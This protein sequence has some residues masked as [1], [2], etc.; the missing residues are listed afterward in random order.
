[1]GSTPTPA[2]G[3]V[4]PQQTGLGTMVAAI[5][6][7]FSQGTIQKSSNPNDLAIQGN[8]FFVVQG[9]GNGQEFTRDGDFSLN[10][11]N[12]LVNATGQRV[13]GYGVDSQYNVSTTQLTPLTIPLG[14]AAVVQ[15]TQN[16]YLEGTLSPSGDLSSQ[17]TTLQTAVLGD[18]A[19]TQ[20]AAG[21]YTTPPEVPTLASPS[22]A[23]T[24]GTLAA[25]S[26]TYEIALTDAAG[27]QGSASPAST[28]VA[29][30]A[31]GGVSLDLSSVTIPSGCMLN[32][33]RSDNGGTY[34]LVSQLHS[35]DITSGSWTDDGSSTLTS[36]ISPTTTTPVTG[37]YEYF[38]SYAKDAWDPANPGQE[39]RPTE[40]GLLTVSDTEPVLSGIP[41]DTADG[42]NYVRVYRCVP[43]ASGA[44]DPSQAYYVGQVDMNADSKSSTVSFIDTTATP[45]QSPDANQLERQGG[46]RHGQHQGGKPA[47]AQR[48]PVLLG[49]QGRRHAPVHRQR[50]RQQP[51]HPIA[52]HQQPNHRLAIARFHERQHGNRFGHHGFQRPDL[53]GQ[54]GR[55]PAHLQRQLRHRQCPGDQRLGHA[56]RD[57]DG[58]ADGEPPLHRHPERGG[59]KRSAD[60]V[61][62][63]S[64]GTPLNVHLTAVLVATSSNSTTY[65]WF[66]DCPQNNTGAGTNI[67]VGSGEITFDGQGNFLSATNSQ[68]QIYRNGTAA[69]SPETFNLNFSGISGLSASS[70]SLQVSQ[71][72]GSAPGT[73]NSYQIG[74]DG[75]IS[76]VFSNGITRTLGQIQLATFANPNG[77]VQT[78]QNMFTQ[79][80]NSG[81]PVANSPGQEGTGSLVAGAEEQSNTDLGGD[82][83]NLITD[84]TM[85]E[86]NS[87]VVT[88]VQQLF[89]DLMNLGRS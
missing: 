52:G 80:V 2:N 85:Y 68:V 7:D 16:A 72:D 26:Y 73:L 69:Q 55:W 60:F 62:Y 44:I 14:T 38:I 43:T 75:T 47:L 28:A 20:P 30:T 78:G 59:A 89:T 21:N 6:T 35:S 76:G 83:V 13:L 45:T 39:S 64:L 29:L 70:S 58:D 66:A 10:A 48:H 19:Y 74:E 37:Q 81:L 33:F 17:G 41:K 42:W 1:M 23:P 50:G 46:C 79:G 82:L 87:R 71:Q 8:G 9:N 77:L 88:T 67:N 18:A 31:A 56:V 27:N 32:V 5:A 57:V 84:S 15:A 3:G 24:T 22:A 11:D 61:A 25:G 4:D 86:A 34:Q 36:T 51:D 63:D 49:L 54:R 53:R 65:Q 12:Q 40:A